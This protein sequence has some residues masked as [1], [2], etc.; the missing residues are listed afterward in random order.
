MANV[1]INAAQYLA[2]TTAGVAA[3]SNAALGAAAGHAVVTEGRS[4]PFPIGVA[5]AMLGGQ[6]E[7]DV[8]PLSDFS[9]PLSKRAAVMRRALRIPSGRA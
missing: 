6:K 9:T 7:G 8:R 5:Q 4:E 1:L 3:A 2:G